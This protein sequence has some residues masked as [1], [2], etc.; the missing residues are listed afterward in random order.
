MADILNQLFTFYLLD[1][2]WIWFSIIPG[3]IFLVTAAIA[4]RQRIQG[5]LVWVV[6]L[7]FAFL[8]ASVP[9]GL[10]SF[11]VSESFQIL[12][13]E[14]IFVL[15]VVGV[16]T[17]IPIL[18]AFYS[19]ALS[20][21]QPQVNSLVTTEQ[22][23]LEDFRPSGQIDKLNPSSSIPESD[24]RVTLLDNDTADQGAPSSNIPKNDLKPP[25]VA[26]PVAPSP[27]KPAAPTPL[28]DYVKAWLIEVN[29]TVGTE[30]MEFQLHLGDNR[31]GR[32]GN[33][34]IVIPHKTVSRNH[35]VIQAMEG[36]IYRLRTFSQTSW[37]KVGGIE[38][39]GDIQIRA[40]DRISFGDVEFEFVT[41]R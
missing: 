22:H 10:F 17:P 3:V 19:Q 39:Q 7:L 41:R 23:N 40:G 24:N 33:P 27:A 5:S 15:G 29:P 26:A 20:V 2:N 35:A 25:V 34:S 14:V 11:G 21:S 13:Q 8:F 38:I 1:G 12:S 18:V 30:P 9:P 4:F 32:E 6:L 16:I 31:I 28:V 36:N 37:T